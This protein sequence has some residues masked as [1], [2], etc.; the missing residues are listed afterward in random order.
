M[1]ALTLENYRNSLRAY[2]KDQSEKNRLLKFVE[3]NTDDELD[4]Y[5]NMSLGFL[6]AIPPLIGNFDYGTFPIPSLLIRQGVIECLISNGI[7]YSR[8][9]LTYNNGGITVRVSDGD[10]YLRHLQI[11][12]TAADREITAL[13]KIKIALN[14]EG[15]FGGVY[16]PYAW[17]HG[18]AAT[19]QPNSIL[20][21]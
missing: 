1:A 14:I 5:I 13:G 17:M 10:R 11:L 16:S 21:G 6:N 2:I 8:N 18:R 19:L 9:D 7:C 15:G 3:E 4:L 20:S 12:T